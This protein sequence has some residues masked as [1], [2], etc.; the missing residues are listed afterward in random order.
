MREHITTVEAWNFDLAKPSFSHSA[1]L[2][3]EN[4]TIYIGTHPRRDFDVNNLDTH[5]VTPSLLRRSMEFGTT[6]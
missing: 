4:G 2:W 3:T 1:V 5:L 6:D